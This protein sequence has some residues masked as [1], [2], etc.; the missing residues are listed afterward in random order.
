MKRAYIYARNAALM[1]ALLLLFGSISSAQSP[2]PTPAPTSAQIDASNIAFCQSAISQST[3]V[4][5]SSAYGGMLGISI[6]I[7]AVMVL[8]IGIAYM[9]GYSFKIEKIIQ[10]SKAEMGEIIITLLIILIFFGAIYSTSPTGFIKIGPSSIYGTYQ[11]DCLLLAGSS[12]NVFRSLATYFIPETYFLTILRDF[13]INLMPLHFGVSFNPLKGF[14]LLYHILNMLTEI[15]G[16]LAALFI[17]LIVF[18]SII[19]SV[20]PVFLFLGIILRTIPWTRAAGGAFLGLFI[21]FYLMFPM[22]LYFMMQ[23]SPVS[24]VSNTLNTNSFFSSFSSFISASGTFL[25]SIAD[26]ATFN[27]ISLFITDIVEPLIFTLFVLIISLIVSYD[28]M[29]LMGDALG[30]PSLSSSNTLKKIL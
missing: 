24:T 9:I 17:A 15:A 2:A 21:G 4:L 1:L 19:Y 16:G 3:A 11:T 6:L 26:M 5:H 10:F 14:G 23:A 18:L 12:V 25:S 27:I 22:L 7:L 20:F 13:T 28:F 8:V 29:E 30:A